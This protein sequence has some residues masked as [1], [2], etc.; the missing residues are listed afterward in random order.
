MK[1]FA[2]TIILMMAAL[3][4]WAQINTTLSRNYGGPGYEQ[5]NRFYQSQDG[6]YYWCG[7]TKAAGGNIPVVFGNNDAWFMKVDA[8]GDSIHSA[9]FGGS[10]DDNLVDILEVDENNYVL[11]FE[12]SSTDNIFAGGPGSSDVWI[13]GLSLT[14]GISSG[15][16]FGGTGFE[17]AS[18]ITPK[19]MG[20]F[21]VT[22]TSRSSDGN[23]NG[24]YGNNDIWL[25]SL[26]PNLAVAWSK[27]FGGSQQDMGIAA[28]QLADGNIM[29]FGT[30]HSTD[31]DVD[32]HI[33]NND[34]WVVKLNS[35]GDI[36]WTKS[37]GG[38]MTDVL[39]EVKHLSNNNFALIGSSN[40]IDGDFM[41]PDG[42]P[43][44][45]HGFYYVI[46]E[47]GDYVHSGTMNTL[48]NYEMTFTDACIDSANHAM[49]FGVTASNSLL[50]CSDPN[51]GGTDVC[52]VDYHG[53][54]S[55]SP[56]LL[57]GE[58]D[59]GLNFINE[60]YVKAIKIGDNKYAFCTNTRSTTLAPDFH[61][62]MDVWLNVFES[63]YLSVNKYTPSQFSVY[64]NPANDFIKV[65]DIRAED[66]W[67]YTIFN[68]QGKLI[69]QGKYDSNGIN[70]GSIQSGMYLLKMQNDKS[71]GVARIAKQ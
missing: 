63:S 43:S 42:I 65:G 30:C 16:P 14:G 26:Q 48:D 38:T 62:L 54:N 11:L 21:L 7:Y 67:L 61:G 69:F 4:S 8:N 68:M 18:R 64:P 1:Q 34:V 19:I 50:N 33:G 36:L 2:I 28:Y 15:L 10:N 57:G 59:E 47:N 46:D 29:L 9:V 39:K 5:M 44:F 22:G 45:Y 24:N 70:I 52:I 55:T 60:K 51:H 71:I 20:G 66:H 56:H 17:S 3:A 13:K 23:L 32:D 58:L 41:L 12:S 31:F 53:I 37:F 6:G 40:S 25:M 35:L 49:A 27:H